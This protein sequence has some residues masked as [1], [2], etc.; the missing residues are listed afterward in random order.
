MLG[1]LFLSLLLNGNL[2]QGRSL[3]LIHTLLVAARA[4]DIKFQ[5]FCVL[6]ILG[7]DL[8]LEF[9]G[10]LLLYLES[11]ARVGEIGVGFVAHV[12]DDGGLL[13]GQISEHLRIS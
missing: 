2:L 1:I 3:A 10:F 13:Y 7:N 8:H 12:G 4:V 5:V 11:G 9:L 6:L